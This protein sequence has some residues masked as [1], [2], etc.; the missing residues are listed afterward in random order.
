M[1]IATTLKHYN[2][3]H[4][5]DT[6]QKMNSEQQQ[7]IIQELENID[8]EEINNLFSQLKTKIEKND[9][10]EPVQYFEK[11]D[12]IGKYEDKGIEIIK[13]N[14]YAVITMAGGQGSRLGHNGPKGTYMLDINGTQASI[15]E[16]LSQKLID[17]KIKYG[18]DIPWYIMTSNNNDAETKEFF[19]NNNFFGLNK[20]KFFKQMDI[21]VLDENGKLLIGKDFLI[22]K[23]GNGNG[24]IYKAL[25][26]QG[27]LEE[28][29]NGGIEWIFVSGVD[30]ILVNMVDPLFIGLNY[31]QGTEIASKPTTK[32]S[33]EEK[34]SVFCKR[35]GR[36]SI[37]EYTEISEE[38]KNM[39]D[40][41]GR[42]VYGQIDIV[43]HLYSLN[44]LKKLKDVKLKYHIAHKKSAYLDKNLKLVTPDSPNT[45]KFEQFIFDGFEEFEK[46]TLLSVERDKEFAPIKNATG[47]DSPETAVNLYIKEKG[48]CQKQ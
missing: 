1:D 13:N 40:A 7:K 14:K 47:N 36:S 46:I 27:I 12:I 42:L 21:P 2:Q 9:N 30:N 28:M 26:E 33:P 48:L 5:L 34:A 41:L 23:A 29:E 35:N 43:S 38:M 16:V 10:F 4:L 18:V 45:Y 19:K 20:V 22:K 15:F 11:K 3:E 31:V 39:R 8:F 25:Y 24:G 37:V 32:K 6:I 44:A 17:A